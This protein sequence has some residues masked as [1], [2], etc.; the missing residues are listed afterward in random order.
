MIIK[1]SNAIAILHP[2]I[3]HPILFLNSILLYF[4]YLSNIAIIKAA[5]NCNVTK[6]SLNIVII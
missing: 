5:M 4:F 1:L 2:K 3:I 6:I